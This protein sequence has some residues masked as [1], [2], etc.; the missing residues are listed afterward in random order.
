MRDPKHFD[1]IYFYRGAVDFRKYISGLCTLIETEFKQDL[2]S[3]S[4][5]VFISKDKKKIKAIYFDNSG[6][7]MWYKI[8][9]KEK[10][11]VP[12]RSNSILELTQKQ[13][14]FLL[15]GYDFSKMK[16]HKKVEIKRF[17]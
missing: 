8:L 4:L 17:S 5:F 9:E 15:E 14:E 11:K 16:E 13:F 10:F 1:K 7:A 2:F 12:Q 3:R 6:F